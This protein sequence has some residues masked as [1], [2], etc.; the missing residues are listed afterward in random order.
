M[1]TPKLLA[2]SAFL[3]LLAVPAAASA[4]TLQ[5]TIK[6]ENLKPGH[7]HGV[8]AAERRNPKSIMNAIQQK[9]IDKRVVNV[10]MGNT[11]EVKLP[12][13][14]SVF[15]TPTGWVGNKLK[16]HTRTIFAG[17]AG[18]E[19]DYTVEARREFFVMGGPGSN[20]ILFVWFSPL[21]G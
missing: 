4:V 12:N 10:P 19:S 14:T 16:I 15:V 13:G 6:L 3:A 2:L 7:P 8:T 5:V 20:G 17:R 21:G 1:R 18:Y 11:A 9:V